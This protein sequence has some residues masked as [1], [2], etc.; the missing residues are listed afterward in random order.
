M[1]YT[2]PITHPHRKSRLSLPT[3]VRFFY[4]LFYFGLKTFDYNII[5]KKGLSAENT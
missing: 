3:D 1:G 5:H 2:F 4:T